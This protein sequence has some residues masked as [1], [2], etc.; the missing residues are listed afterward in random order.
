MHTNQRDPD[1]DRD[2]DLR[3][4][5]T[6]ADDTGLVRQQELIVESERLGF[7]VEDDTH[8]S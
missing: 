2:E 1:H 4:E 5:V 7:P 3:E 8:R 6:A